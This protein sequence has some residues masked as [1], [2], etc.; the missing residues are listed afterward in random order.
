MKKKNTKNNNESDLDFL[1]KN[2][3]YFRCGAYYLSQKI[4]NITM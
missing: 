2:K 1:L 4:N 3:I